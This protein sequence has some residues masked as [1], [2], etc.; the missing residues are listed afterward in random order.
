MR[1]SVHKVEQLRA[2]YVFRRTFG[3]I[4]S[5]YFQRHKIRTIEGIAIGRTLR[6][7]VTSLVFT[8]K[9]LQK[10]MQTSYFRDGKDQPGVLE[11]LGH[12]Q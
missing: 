9:E 2:T 12:C 6:K 10:S 1:G 11:D 4:L 8:I 3:R 7:G 5:G